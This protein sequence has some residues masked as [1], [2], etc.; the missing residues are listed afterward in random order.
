[1]LLNRATTYGADRSMYMSTF[2]SA[3]VLVKYQSKDGITLF[4]EILEK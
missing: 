2:V 1:M 4:N 3:I